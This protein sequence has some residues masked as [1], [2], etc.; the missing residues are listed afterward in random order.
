MPEEAAIPVVED[1]IEGAETAG[2]GAGAAKVASALGAEA[3][4]PA[5]AE[6]LGASTASSAPGLTAGVAPTAAP[7]LPSVSAVQDVGAQGFEGAGATPTSAAPEVDTTTAQTNAD[8]SLYGLTA[9]STAPGTSSMDYA[10][11]APG[12]TGQGLQFTG[13]TGLTAPSGALST[14]PAT[15]GAF[16]KAISAITNN[17]LTAASLG[18]TGLSAYQGKEAA[19]ALQSSL[20]QAGAQTSNTAQQLLNQYQTG[21]INPAQDKQI[22][23]WTN[24]Q[25]AQIKQRYAS[26]GRDPNTDSA[27]QA[28]MANAEAQAVAMRDQALQGVLTQGL[29]A[30]GVA[31]GPTTQAIMAGYNANTAAQQSMAQ[32]MQT[33]AMLQALQQGKQ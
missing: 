11:T 13:Q 24:N 25:M 21:T 4:A 19:K 1:V 7:A 31:A 15:P 16:D 5:Q 10:L 17:P 27:A 32:G 18:M 6:Y 28:E 22:T 26:M 2:A 8:Q 3:L 23:D 29:S 12:S 33:L 14:T 20:Q 9:P 30:A